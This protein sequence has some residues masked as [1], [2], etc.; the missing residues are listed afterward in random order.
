MKVGYA[1]ISTLDQ[2]VVLKAQSRELNNDG[3]KKFFKEQVA[4]AGAREQL[5]AALEF[6]NKGDIL[7]VT[8]LQWLARSSA[9]LVQ[10]TDTLKA[11]GAC[12]HVLDMGLNTDTSSG[13]HM[14]TMLRAVALFE[15]EI[16]LERQREGIAKAKAEGKYRGRKPTARA[17]TDDVVRLKNEGV[18]PTEIARRLKI[19]RAS[20]YRILKS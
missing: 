15:R 1:R 6:V 20:V 3:C 11:K 10:I 8:K 14:L 13:R 5:D 2:L 12:L 9:H 7:V 18:G 16:K 17:K 19:G 4:S